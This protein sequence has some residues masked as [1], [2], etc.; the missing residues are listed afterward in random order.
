MDQVLD[1]FQSLLEKSSGFAADRVIEWYDDNRP[2]VEKGNDIIWFRWTDESP[3][4]ESGAGRHG[5]RVSTM[6]EVNLVSRDT[7][8]RS[9]RLGRRHLANRYLLINGIQGQMLFSGYKNRSG[10]FPPQPTNPVTVLSAS[11][12]V[13]DKL[14]KTERDKR[15]ESGFMTSKF[16]VRFDTVLPLIVNDPQPLG[17]KAWAKDA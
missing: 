9:K 4:S 2:N 7:N 3:D 12:M 13:I 11:T 8:Q 10:D 15:P 17:V 16:G 1:A 6:V 14:P 5:F